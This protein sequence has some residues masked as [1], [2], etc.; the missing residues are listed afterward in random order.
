MQWTLIGAIAATAVAPSYADY[1]L[2]DCI[3]NGLKGVS[4]DVAARFVRK[5]C[6]DK[7]EDHRHQLLNGLKQEYGDK[8]DT[9]SVVESKAYWVETANSKSIEITNVGKF[10]E[11]T[12]TYIDLSVLPACEYSQKVLYS[13]KLTLTPTSS[14]KLVFPS[15][16]ETICTSIKTVRGKPTTWKDF[17]LSGSVM[18][19]DKN[20]FADVE[21]AV[22]EPIALPAPL[23]APAAPS[24]WAAQVPYKK[25]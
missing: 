17:S 10:P 16:S 22:S 4:S 3:L 12:I 13:Y 6:E 24:T 2:S 1:S 7:Q 18:P 25:K 8:I 23:A 19:L 14:I 9:A 5:A 21:T 15:N 11:R 20:P